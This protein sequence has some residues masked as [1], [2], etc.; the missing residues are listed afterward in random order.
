MRETNY[1][2]LNYKPS[3]RERIGGPW[4][5]SLRAFVLTSPVGILFQPIVEPDFW[6][7]YSHYLNWFAISALGYLAFGFV[8]FVGNK[9]IFPNREDKPAPVTGIILI[10]M[11]AGMARS[12]TIGTNLEL[13]GLSGINGVQRLP[14]G[15][16]L[17]FI[18]VVTAALILDAKFRFERQLHELLGEQKDLLTRQRRRVDKFILASSDEAI[19]ELEM[20]Q[21]RLQNVIRDV[22]VRASDKNSHWSML[23]GQI[24]NAAMKVIH[25]GQPD[26]WTSESTESELRGSRSDALKAISRTP[27]FNIPIAL[28]FTAITVFFGGARL[29]PFELFLSWMAIG[30]TSNL[31]VMITGKIL[32]SRSSHNSSI[33][34]INML[35]ALMIL[36][37]VAP[38]F[39]GSANYSTEQFRLFTLAGTAFE[40]IWIFATGY[41]QF[42]QENRQTIIDKASEENEL[43]RTE[44]EYWESIESH[45]SQNNYSFAAAMD[46]ITSDL[47]SLIVI[48]RPELTRGPIQFANSIMPAIN[49]RLM[50]VEQ[51]SLESELDRIERTWNSTA[52]VIWTVTG[53]QTSVALARRAV[54][55]LEICVSKSVRHGLASVISVTVTRSATSVEIAVTDNGQPHDDNNTGL[56]IELLKELSNDTWVRTRTGGLNQMMATI[57]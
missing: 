1:M 54:G 41:M 23:S 4:A 56:G 52:N 45:L 2:A 44:F 34:F 30:L 18:W 43:L 42:V 31:L 57:S 27:L 11:L 22:T 9:V 51:M 38:T 14:F 26:T 47:E 16:F 55:V 12:L 37:L 7:G 29:Y 24:S 53:E 36:A 28:G 40:F 6:N 35:A 10:A 48:E 13:F 15:A 46:R 25:A 3:I 39:I 50:P 8:L 17:G 20:S 19:P 5:F 32:I 33:G 49:E 21:R